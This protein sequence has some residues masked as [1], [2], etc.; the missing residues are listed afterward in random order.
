[1]KQLFRVIHNLCDSKRQKTVQAQTELL[2]S[3]LVWSRGA[4]VRKKT[5][6][7]PEQGLFSLTI[8]ISALQMHWMLFLCLLLCSPSPPPSYTKIIHTDLEQWLAHFSLPN[9]PFLQEK[10][11]Q[12]T[13][14]IVVY[15]Y[16]SLS[17]C[18]IGMTLVPASH[19]P[20]FIAA[21]LSN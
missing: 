7:P 13:N 5:E 9:D 11:F 4:N 6:S 17:R 14:M 8:Q 20:F 1:M 16:C 12:L 18:H 3:L 2:H 15:V 19:S 10:V 21:I